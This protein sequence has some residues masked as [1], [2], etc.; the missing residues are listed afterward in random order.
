MCLCG[1]A[2]F[3]QSV[4][5]FMTYLSPFLTVRVLLPCSV[6]LWRIF[7]KV[8]RCIPQLLRLLVIHPYIQTYPSSRNISLSISTFST[9]FWSLVLFRSLVAVYKSVWLFGLSDK[10]PLNINRWKC[11]ILQNVILT[12]CS[13][14][15]QQG[16]D[17]GQAKKNTQAR[18]TIRDTNMNTHNHVNLH[19]PPLKK[20]SHDSLHNA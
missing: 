15:Q 9:S 5:Y 10:W 12:R 20:N 14:K 6:N 19:I 7:I 16:H 4:W 3:F 18:E 13:C 2:C 17:Q 11:E 8:W 1:C